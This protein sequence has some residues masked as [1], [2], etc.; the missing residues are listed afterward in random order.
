MSTIGKEAGKLSKA[1]AKALQVLSEN[2]IRFMTWGTEL[3]AG[4]TRGVTRSTLGALLRKKLAHV[5]YVSNWQTWS[6][7]D[8]GRLAL[9]RAKGEE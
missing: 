3:Y 6:I 7:T 4:D 2:E 5:A 9:S 8:A 1:Q